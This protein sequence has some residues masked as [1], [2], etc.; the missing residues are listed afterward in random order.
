MQ[1]DKSII[2]TQET[3]VCFFSKNYFFRFIVI[4]VHVHVHV[5]VVYEFICV[6]EVCN[7]L[8]VYVYM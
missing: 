4:G 1:P 7:M 3:R 6:M 2:F 8:L 5:N